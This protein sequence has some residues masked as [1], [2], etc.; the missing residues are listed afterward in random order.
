[1]ALIGKDR[2]ARPE[3]A[4][5]RY[6]NVRGTVRNQA[7]AQEVRETLNSVSVNTRNL[8]FVELD[9]TA[10]QGWNLAAKGCDFI[11]HVASTLCRCEPEESTG[12]DCS[13]S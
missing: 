5:G 10:D 9:L 4:E 12:N 1:M 3:L 2:G 7:K 11:M 8:T 13:S 6:A